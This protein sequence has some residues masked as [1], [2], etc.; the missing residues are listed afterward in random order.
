MIEEGIVLCCDF[1]YHQS[2]ILIFFIF[3]FSI[4]FIDNNLLCRIGRFFKYEEDWKHSWYVDIDSCQLYLFIKKN[5]GRYG[6]TL[7]KFNSIINYTAKHLSY[8]ILLY[9]YIGKM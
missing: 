3:L 8:L 9:L 5:K 2:Q 4:N 1:G 6:N 7:N